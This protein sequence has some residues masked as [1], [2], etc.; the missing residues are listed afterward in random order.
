MRHLQSLL[1]EN[2]LPVLLLGLFLASCHPT[3][4]F[5]NP[6]ENI[7]PEEQSS[8]PKLEIDQ[9]SFDCECPSIL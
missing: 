2:I 9:Q 7:T 6:D 3:A 1:L 4:N 8:F 5:H